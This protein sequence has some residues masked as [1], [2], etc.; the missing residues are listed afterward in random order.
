[1]NSDKTPA[2]VP[3]NLQEAYTEMQR[4]CQL[5]HEEV[6]QL[7]AERKVLSGALCS[8]LLDQTPIDDEIVFAQIGKE[9][10]LREFLDELWAQM[11]E[12]A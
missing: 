3:P 11:D 5:L 8:L 12:Q 6:A 1:M 9:Q 10:P 7:H 2:S 4:E